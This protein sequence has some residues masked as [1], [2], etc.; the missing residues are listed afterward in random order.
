MVKN[1]LPAAAEARAAIA[2][3]GLAA[4]PAKAELAPV[5]GMTNRVFAVTTAERRFWLRLPGLRTAAYI[6]RRAEAHNARAAAAA[7]VAPAVLHAGPDGTMATAY[8]RGARPL[9]AGGV[10][11]GRDLRLVAAC[12]RRLHRGAA[13][14]RGTFDAV[15]SAENY[16]ALS[17]PAGAVGARMAAVV[18]AMRSAASALDTPAGPSAPCHCDPVPGNILI[19]DGRALLVDWEYSGMADPL[20]DLAYFVAAAGL[21][22]AAEAAFLHAYFGRAPTRTERARMIVHK[23]QAAGL[24]AAWALMR[25]TECDAEDA[26]GFAA[27]GEAKLTEAE[28]RLG[29]EDLAAAMAAAR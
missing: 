14:F 3:A 9:G 19:G 8:V 6:D 28:A 23:A 5:F 15:G 16:L 26:P 2:A 12:F 20:W 10:P 22:T 7:G 17:P 24:A 1:D 18:A 13:A 21:P 11:P 29:A 4:D 27:Y 25:Q